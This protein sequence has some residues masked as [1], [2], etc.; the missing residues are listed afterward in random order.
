M[1]HCY[2]WIDCLINCTELAI[3]WIC[4]FGWYLTGILGSV[5]IGAIQILQVLQ[6]RA[7]KHVHK[8]GRLFLTS[9]LFK[10]EG[11]NVC[12]MYRYGVSIFVHDSIYSLRLITFFFKVQRTHMKLEIGL[13]W[14][15]IKRKYGENAL[16]FAWAK[17]LWTIT[18]VY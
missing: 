12:S 16:N 9:L 11:M 4:M 17:I 1:R 8:V 6:K 13:N 14:L 15:R 7:L 10:C 2:H 18:C 5:N 3:Q